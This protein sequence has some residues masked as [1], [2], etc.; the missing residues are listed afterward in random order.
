MG[1]LLTISLDDESDRVNYFNALLAVGGTVRD[2]VRLGLCSKGLRSWVCTMVTSLDLASFRTL[3]ASLPLTPRLD[4][5][6]HFKGQLKRFQSRCV[7]WENDPTRP[8]SPR[9]IELILD[10]PNNVVLNEF[11]LKYCSVLLE[12]ASIRTQG[13][14]SYYTVQW[15][16]MLDYA[17]KTACARFRQL[18]LAAQLKEDAQVVY[19]MRVNSV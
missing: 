10:A 11:Y 17:V 6:K 9:L 18:E 5:G 19:S 16:P 7:C 15:Y 2:V 4:F 13:M 12:T 1:N 3:L 8:K 14:Y